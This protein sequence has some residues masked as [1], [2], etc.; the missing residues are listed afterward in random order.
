MSSVNLFTRE[1]SIKIVYYGP[2]LGG[3]TSSLQYVHRALKSDSRGQLVSL[4]TGVD[5]T[6]YFDFL[7]VKL[8]K[9]RGYSIRVQLYT[10]PGQVHYNSTRKLVLAGAD[11]VVFVADSQQSRDTAN[12]ESYQNLRDNLAEQGMKLE[13]VP[14]IF[15]FNKRDVPDLLSIEQMNAALNASG[16]PTFETVATSGRGVFEALKSITTLV[17][18]DLRRRGIWD[19]GEASRPG[20]V[21]TEFNKQDASIAQKVQALSEAADAVARMEA[22]LAEAHAPPVASSSSPAPAAA[23]A[24]GS[25]F[26]AGGAQGG[27]AREPSGTTPPPGPLPPS[28]SGNSG[29]TR[30]PVAPRIPTGEGLAELLPQG[31]A[32]DQVAAVEAELDRGDYAEAVRIAARAF[33][34]AS[35]AESSSMEIAPVL[36]ALMLG[37][38][39]RRY[40]RF[41]EAASRAE[42]GHCSSEDALFAAFFLVDSLLER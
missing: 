36:H 24:T 4:A 21:S 8:P 40:L 28:T 22:S 9:L 5:R 20:S 1:I 25:M 12:V 31:P 26:A 2:G 30:L 15:Q 39:G 27:T 29:V 7:P 11:G 18:N 16:V 38:G 35:R 10:V 14:H 33:A 17:L 13:A 32:R 41:C 3:K 6:L 23:R 19:G 34:D 42:Q 37:V